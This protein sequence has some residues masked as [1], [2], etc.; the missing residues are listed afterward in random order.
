MF[1]WHKKE[2]PFLGMA[3]MGG[4]VVSK[5]AG[6]G[7]GFSATGGTEIESGG[8]KYHVFTY[9][10]SYPNSVNFEVSGEGDV[11][12]LLVGGG[13]A[14]TGDDGA[15]G[16]AGGVCYGST[17]PFSAGTYSVVVG[18]GGIFNGNRDN[19]TNTWGMPSS[20]VHPVGTIIAYGGQGTWNSG[21]S[22]G[23]AILS[24]HGGS[25][26]TYFG[27]GSG[28][29]VTNPTSE[30]AFIS[31]IANA[32]PG[33]PTFGGLIANYGNT[34]GPASNAY[35]WNGGGGG[36]AGSAG[37][38]SSSGGTKLGGSGQ[39]FPSFPAPVISPAIPAPYR[40]DWTNA[41]GPTGLYGGGGGGSVENP[42]T[43]GFPGPGGGSASGIPT[44]SP[45]V[46]G[47]GGG[48]G[49]YGAAPA[50]TTPDSGGAGIV[51]IRYAI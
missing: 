37:G 5:L 42:S 11:E 6:G 31:P 12:I 17:V 10:G 23:Y 34:G 48:Q 32:Q 14:S 8:Y 50:I 16:G 30:E 46:W 49:S 33:R 43:Y 3:G 29:R 40:T 24:P 13:G 20:I 18:R 19:N 2:K 7:G 38:A 15:G 27:S 21:P 35:Y 41:V 45:G 39:P 36:G 47:T 4:G 51:I 28:G 44:S 22:P 26:E 9:P 25:N 1:E